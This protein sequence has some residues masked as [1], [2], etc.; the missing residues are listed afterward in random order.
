MREWH[1][2][3]QAVW[4]VRRE[5]SRGGVGAGIGRQADAL[6][7]GILRLRCAPLRMTMELG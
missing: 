6:R 7:A 4:W 3:E 2:G 1:V 5:A